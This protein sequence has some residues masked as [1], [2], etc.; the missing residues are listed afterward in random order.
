MPTPKRSVHE[1]NVSDERLEIALSWLRANADK[2]RKVGP[3]ANIMAT[4]GLLICDERGHISE[5]ALLSA[6]SDPDARSAAEM[7]LSAVLD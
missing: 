5:D 3:E 1:L 7:L 2:M 4:V 6:M